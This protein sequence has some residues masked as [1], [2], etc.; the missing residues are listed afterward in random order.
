MIHKILALWKESGGKGIIS[1][2]DDMTGVRI[3][4]TVI[5]AMPDRNVK[6]IVPNNRMYGYRSY[7]TDKLISGNNLM[8]PLIS[9]EKYHVL[10]VLNADLLNDYHINR[11]LK[12]N[13]KYIIVCTG[14][15]NGLSESLNDLPKIEFVDR[16]F[17]EYNFIVPMNED[18]HK[19][20][21][22]IENR[23]NDI[24]GV[25]RNYD[26]IKKCVFGMDRKSAYDCRNEFAIEN[27]WSK[28]LNTSIPLFAQIDKFYNPD[29][30]Y[31]QAVLYQTLVTERD[32]VVSKCQDKVQAVLSILKVNKYKRFIV[33]AKGND[34]CDDIAKQAKS[35]KIATES[36]HAE[37]PNSTLRDD[38]GNLILVKT[39]ANKGKAK[40]F[41]TKLVNDSIVARFNNKKLRALITT[42]TLDKS[43]KIEAV[44]AIICTSP[45]AASYYDLKS[46]IEK[47]SFNGDIIVI[48]VTFDVMKDLKDVKNRQQRLGVDAP[49]VFNLDEII[50]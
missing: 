49:S 22:D 32:K 10:C 43:L 12:F 1:V 41:G 5:S 7:F 33:L 45:K 26:N 31:D 50:F 6:V 34:M 38:N 24:I 8:N 40:I 44:D 28:D 46:R 11:I 19:R 18:T 17:R 15:F 47:L 23:M 27:G 30:L 48:N 35:L 20:Y 39:G 36:I 3:A 9:A 16:K 2:E 13:Y 14:S 21:F 37:T 42:G 4:E 29:A 25:F